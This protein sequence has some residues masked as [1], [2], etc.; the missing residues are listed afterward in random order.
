[1]ELTGE[2]YVDGEDYIWIPEPKWTGINTGTEETMYYGFL[3]NQKEGVRQQVI[4]ASMLSHRVTAVPPYILLLIDP[5]SDYSIPIVDGNKLD[6]FRPTMSK[7][8]L[9]GLLVLRELIFAEPFGI[10]LPKLST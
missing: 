5:K 8:E 4:K 2:W 1:M 3:I 9:S 7:D 6:S 10:Q